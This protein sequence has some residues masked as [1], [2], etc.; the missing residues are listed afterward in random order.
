MYK[1]EPGRV[2]RVADGRDLRAV[3]G[4]GLLDTNHDLT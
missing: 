3:R 2:R 4:P 1:R